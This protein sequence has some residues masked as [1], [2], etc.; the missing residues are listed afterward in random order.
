MTNSKRKELMNMKG[1]FGTDTPQH[2]AYPTSATHNF[3][4][5]S[6][7]DDLNDYVDMITVLDTA[8]ENDFIHI[9]INTPGGSVNTTISIIH[10]MLRSRANVVTHADGEVASAGTLIFFAASLRIVYPYSHFMF[11]DASGG[12]L[13]KINENIKNIMATSELIQKLAYDLY[14]PTFT[15]EEVDQILE[16]RDY[17]CDAEEMYDRIKAVEEQVNE[18]L[19]EE[20]EQPEEEEEGE[21][22]VVVNNPKLKSHGEYGFIAAH[23][24]GGL[25]KVQFDSGKVAKLK[26]ENLEEVA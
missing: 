24:G 7:I 16:G 11:H 21:V 15:E 13:G 20:T 17:Y 9:Y 10:A 18:E 1:L 4:I 25:V 19:A 3:Y 5:Y 23:L 6:A 2:R 14:C 8:Q 22:N 26:Y 12:T